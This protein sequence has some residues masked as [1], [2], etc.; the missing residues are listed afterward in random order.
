[1]RQGNSFAPVLNDSYN[2]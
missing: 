1:M 2:F